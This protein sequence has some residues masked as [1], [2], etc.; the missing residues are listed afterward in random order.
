MNADN[1][2]MNDTLKR[3]CVSDERY[4][5]PVYCVYLKIKSTAF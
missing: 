2:V 4:N 5:Y 3:L 1:L